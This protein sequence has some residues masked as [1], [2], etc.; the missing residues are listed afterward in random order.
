MPGLLSAR[1]RGAL[2]SNGEI[3]IF[4][5][6]DVVLDKFWFDAIVNTFRDPSVQIVGGRSLPLYETAPPEWLK[7]LWLTTEHGEICGDLSLLDFGPNPVEVD[8]TFVWGLNFSI[9]RRAFFELGG[10]NPDLVPKYLQRYQGDGE[11]GLSL[12]AR[13]NGLKAVYQPSALVF[14][15]IPKERLTLK[16]FKNRAFYQGVCDSYTS[17]RDSFLDNPD[18]SSFKN[19]FR[20]AR[21]ARTLF[22]RFIRTFYRNITSFSSTTINL[23]FFLYYLKGYVYHQQQ[24]NKDYTL[25]RWVTRKQYLINNSK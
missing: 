22:E 6:D 24:V 7:C 10:F 14:H 5:D 23:F 13:R 25:F 15:Q 8:P 21:S 4:I 2:E 18:Y 20:H 1:H 11:T 17:I 9:R 19:P 3:L 12:K 16:Y